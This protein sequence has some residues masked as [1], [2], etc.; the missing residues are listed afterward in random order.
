MSLKARWSGI[1]FLS[2]NLQDSSL[3][4]AIPISSNFLLKVVS[5]GYM[6]GNDRCS[7]SAESLA[8]LPLHSTSAIH[9]CYWISLLNTGLTKW[10]P[11]FEMYDNNHTIYIYYCGHTQQR[12]RMMMY[13]K[14]ASYEAT[15]T[16]VIAWSRAFYFEF[17]WWKTS[18][19]M[20]N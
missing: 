20:I 12:T 7:T 17:Q 14:H 5:V 19:D 13:E 18:N 10:T 6:R 15:I 16:V 3:T 11:S 4:S 9:A 8:C 2:T 1:S